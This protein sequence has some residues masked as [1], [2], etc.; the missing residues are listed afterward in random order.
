MRQGVV[1]EQ[2]RRTRS[3]KLLIFSDGEA[4]HRWDGAGCDMV[5]GTPRRS[6]LTKHGYSTK[7]ARLAGDIPEGQRHRGAGSQ[8][9]ATPRAASP[10]PTVGTCHVSPPDPH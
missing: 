1:R 5:V 6:P 2:V 10:A 9:P 4:L 8:Q 3:S 7:S